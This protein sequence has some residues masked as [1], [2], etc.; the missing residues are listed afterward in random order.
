MKEFEQQIKE[1]YNS[2][3]LSTEQL[4]SIIHQ[5]ENK[6][7]RLI[8]ILH[9]LKYAAI[10]FVFA[11]T[12]YVLYF[13]PKQQQVSVINSYAKEIAFNHQ[14]QLVSEIKTSSISELN[15]KMD[16]LDFEILL[17][18]KITNNLKLKGGRYCSIDDRIAAQ[19]KFENNQ[20]KII[21]C[22]IFRKVEKFVFDKKILNNNIEVVIW[23]NGTLI[24]GLATDN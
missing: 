3:S 4:E 8:S 14:K 21:T 1:F 12:V 20:G 16:K 13:L 22:Y 6:K 15:N 18:L 11:G 19:L 7:N 9:L 23:D 24:F 10:F 17:P 2:K 5:S